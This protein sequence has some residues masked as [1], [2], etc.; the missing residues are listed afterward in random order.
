MSGP[1]STWMGDRLGIRDAVGKALFYFCFEVLPKLDETWN[2]M[3]SLGISRLVEVGIA[4]TLIDDSIFSKSHVCL[5]S[6]VFTK[7]K[8]EVWLF[9]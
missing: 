1:V 9:R 4:G 2:T 3:Y 8:I 7:K 5:S 6:V